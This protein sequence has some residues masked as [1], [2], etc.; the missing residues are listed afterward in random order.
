[1]SIVQDRILQQLK[2][3]ILQS[4]S[5]SVFVGFGGC[6]CPIL[7]SEVRKVVASL[8]LEKFLLD[9]DLDADAMMFLRNMDRFN[10]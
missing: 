1:M 5:F 9:F 6:V 8:L 4:M 7:Q 2:F 3:I 10:S